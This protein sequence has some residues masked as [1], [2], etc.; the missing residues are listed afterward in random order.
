MTDIRCPAPGCEVT[1]P[2]TTAPEVLLKLLDIHE[3]T[4][5]PAPAPITAPTATGVKA[6]KVKRPV[7][8]A[9]GTTEEWTYFTQRWSEYK[10]ATRLTGQDIIFQLLECCDE[11]LRKDLSRSFNNL[12]SYEEPTLLGHI[13]SLAVRQENVM[14]ARLQLQQMR[15]DRDEP[16][17]TFSARIK[18]QAN[19]C[20]YNIKCECGIQLSYSDHM[21]RDTLIVGLADDDIRLDVLGQTNQE[22]SLDETIRFIEAKESGKRSAGRMNPTPTAV[23]AA[24]DAASSTYRQ[25]ERNRLK[26][27]HPDRKTSTQTQAQPCSYCGKGG[28]SSRG[29]T[30]WI[31]A[32]PTTIPAPTAVSHTTLRVSAVNHDCPPIKITQRRQSSRPSARS[33]SWPT[34]SHWTTMYTILC[35][36]RGKSV[37]PHLNRLSTSKFKPFQLTLKT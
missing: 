16:A 34:Q 20:Q 10:Q 3:R 33:N 29:K 17:R 23:P 14:V 21:I 1:W 12:T 2:S 7:I 36:T 24:I 11:V 32:L 28:H 25:M 4:T 15:Q 13:K 5:H 19:V 26:G 35:V 31:I 8:S 9:S 22:M 30:V 18:G 27:R 37:H 6:E